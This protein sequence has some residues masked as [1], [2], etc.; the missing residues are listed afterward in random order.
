MVHNAKSGST[1]RDISAAFCLAVATFLPWPSLALA[2]DVQ[3]RFDVSVPTGGPFPSD[4][5]TVSDNSQKTGILS[6]AKISSHSVEDVPCS[7]GEPG[8]SEVA[9][10]TAWGPRP[11][12]PPREEGSAR[13]VPSGLTRGAPAW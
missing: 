10:P 13:W 8:R 12:G 5:F 7:H 9:Q 3:A 11:Q 2:T 1:I 4:R 6:L